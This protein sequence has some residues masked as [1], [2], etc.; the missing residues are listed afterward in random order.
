MNLIPYGKVSFTRKS[1]SGL[2]VKVQTE[3][4]GPWCVKDQGCKLPVRIEQWVKFVGLK[5]SRRCG[6]TDFH[7]HAKIKLM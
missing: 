1:E 7:G 6:G 5:V 3:L 4:L 2:K